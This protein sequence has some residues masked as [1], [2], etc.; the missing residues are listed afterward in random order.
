[1]SAYN[2]PRNA[3]NEM[4]RSVASTMQIEAY[5]KLFDAACLLG[6]KIEMQ[7]AEVGLHQAVQNYLDSTQAKY[8]IIRSQMRE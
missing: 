6:S 8:A 7:R 3:Q 5:C 2:L 4:E 1:M